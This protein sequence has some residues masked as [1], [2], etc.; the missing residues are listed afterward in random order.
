M[1]FQG[2]KRVCIHLGRNFSLN[3]SCK[4]KYIIYFVKPG[5]VYLFIFCDICITLIINMLSYS[6]NKRKSISTFSCFKKIL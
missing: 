6:I 1:S 3:Y 2:I 4:D 5:K